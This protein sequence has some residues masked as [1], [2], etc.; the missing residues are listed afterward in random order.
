MRGKWKTFVIVLNFY[1]HNQ[2]EC[3]PTAI[4]LDSLVAVSLQQGFQCMVVAVFG[5]VA[6]EVKIIEF[7][8]VLDYVLVHVALWN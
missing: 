5:G 8:N 4:R 2:Q 7:S 6:S 1:T 3:C